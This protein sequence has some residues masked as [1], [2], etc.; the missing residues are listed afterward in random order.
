MSPSVLVTGSLARAGRR[1]AR[2]PGDLV[3]WVGSGRPPGPAE[4]AAI[5][6]RVA[7][8]ALGPRLRRALR[9]ALAPHQ[10]PAPPPPARR[11][12]AG[13]RRALA[14][15]A[16]EA[17]GALVVVRV[18]ARNARHLAAL[19][20]AARDAGCAAVQLVWDGRSPPPELA[21]AGVFAALEAARAAPGR[22]PVVLTPSGRAT[23]ALG[24]ALA[25]RGG[26]PR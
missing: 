15:R 6:V 14:R 3:V 22:A 21:E 13:S 11:L 4:F 7:R 8:G 20:G 10:G 23:A 16:G 9:S 24:L 25:A 5:D 17:A 12:V 2:R 26:G 19:V 1:A 18:T